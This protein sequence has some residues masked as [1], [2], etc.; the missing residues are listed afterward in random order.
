LLDVENYR[1]KRKKTLEQLAKNL[2]L[3]ALRT[4]KEVA[5]EPMSPHERRI[6]HLA[7]KNNRDVVTFSHG[8]EPHRKVIISPR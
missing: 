1:L 7:L 5:L 6:I 3:K 2:A 8:E 4:K